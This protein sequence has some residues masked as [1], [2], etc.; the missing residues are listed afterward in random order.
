MFLDD[1]EFR[2]F[3][4]R[5]YC[6][7]NWDYITPEALLSELGKDALRKSLKK[8]IH[9]GKKLVKV[10][11]GGRASAPEDKGRYA[12][13]SY[14]APVRRK[15]K[16]RGGYRGPRKPKGP[17]EEKSVRDDFFPPMF[18]LDMV[19]KSAKPPPPAEEAPEAPPPRRASARTTSPRILDPYQSSAGRAYYKP[20]ADGDGDDDD[21]D[22]DDLS[23]DDESSQEAER[24]E[25]SESSGASEPDDA[26]ARIV[27]RA[28]RVSRKPAKL[29]SPPPSAKSK[30][31][32]AKPGSKKRARPVSPQPGEA[33]DGA[34]KAKRPVGRPRTG[35]TKWSVGDAV[36]VPEPCDGGEHGRGRWAKE[37]GQTYTRAI[38]TEAICAMRRADDTI[39]VARADGSEFI[40]GAELARKTPPFGKRVTVVTPTGGATPTSSTGDRASSEGSVGDADDRLPDAPPLPR[41]ALRAR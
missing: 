31:G 19:P 33:D 5:S 38:V 17:V 41:V 10:S 36:Y 15:K 4:K 27:S 21:D 37:R 1:Y 24:G 18:G 2:V 9:D 16:R 26:P 39:T 34:P 23:G 3:D 28:G 25:V 6:V 30:R 35:K 40:V 22:D 7:Q 20:R 32:G 12:A 29:R 13:D 14:E 11:R 8:A